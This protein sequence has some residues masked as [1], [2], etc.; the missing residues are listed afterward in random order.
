MCSSDVAEDLKRLFPKGC[1]ILG[2]ATP[3]IVCEGAQLRFFSTPVGL[4][5]EASVLICADFGCRFITGLFSRFTKYGE[6]SVFTTLGLLCD[7]NQ[8]CLFQLWSVK[9]FICL[10]L[11]KGGCVSVDKSVEQR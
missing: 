11:C 10:G 7:Q 3:G 6:V 9:W 1:D 5:E 4:D 8:F 2:I